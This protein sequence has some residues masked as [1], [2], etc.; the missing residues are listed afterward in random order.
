MNAF[1]VDRQMIVAPEALAAFLAL[2]CFLTWKRNMGLVN[3]S[4]L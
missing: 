1:V 3:K 2:V 4:D